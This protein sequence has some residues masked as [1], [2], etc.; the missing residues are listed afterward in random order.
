[1]TIKYPV[2]V[3]LSNGLDGTYPV[4]DSDCNDVAICDTKA[5]AKTIANALNAMNEFPYVGSDTDNVEE[6]EKRYF[7]SRYA[8]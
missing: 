5:L 3:G 6:W 1:M 8:E 4:I 2:Q 7:P